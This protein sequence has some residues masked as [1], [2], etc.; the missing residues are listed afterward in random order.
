[1][2]TKLAIEFKKSLPK[3]NDVL[4]VLTD[5][6]GA[7][8]DEAVKF[9]K[10]MG[11]SF[12]KH[13]K[14]RSFE[15]KP[16]SVL[17]ITAPANLDLS[18]IIIIGKPKDEAKETDWLKLGGCI[19]KAVS[20]FAD[21]HVNVMLELDGK[22]SAKDLAIVARGAL[23]GSYSFKTYKTKKDDKENKDKSLQ[24]LTFVAANLEQVK[25]AYEAQEAIAQGVILARDLVNEPANILGPVEFADK[26]AE[27]EALG[28][29]IEI[30]DEKALKKENMRALLGVNQGSVRPPRVAIM[31]WKG[32]KKGDK[33]VALVGKGVTFD[34]GGISIK[35]AGGME[36]MKGDMGGAAAVVGAMHAIAGRKAKANVTG[37]IGLVE[38]MPDGNAQRP[39]DIVVSRKGLT[40]E[41]INTDAEGRLVLAD[42]LDYIIEKD[43]PTCVIDLAT[44]TGAV[45]VALGHEYAAVYA[46][47]EALCEQ[48]NAAGK[49]TGDKLW[50]MP[51]GEAYDKLI[52]S[53]FADVKNV[54]GRYGGSITAAQFLK[55][56]V[57]E[58]PW[59]HLDIAGTAFG[60][61]TNETNPAWGSGF[62]VMVLDRFVA[63]NYEK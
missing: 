35:P 62:G 39:G 38:N 28:V 19:Y 49:V 31:R 40:I 22:T 16:F 54:G 27:L 4:V 10:E 17:E 9:I 60:A 59:A 61:P 26:A 3:K 12:E 57:D 30:L 24:Q 48:L 7:F 63:D 37:I 13:K 50:P 34:T 47:D 25:K 41:V 32:G 6:K 11:D 52:D 2:P 5:E 14:V 20:N 1:M 29:E 53:Q 18:R 42:V 21:D 43:D 44:L 36:D 58:R 56:F 15:G 23:L 51:L 33:P 46:S 45:V 8:G 55:R